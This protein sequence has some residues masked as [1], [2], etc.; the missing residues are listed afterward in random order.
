MKTMNYL[1]TVVFVLL[2]GSCT[3]E[4]HPVEEQLAATDFKSHKA[5][6]QEETQEIFALDMRQYYVLGQIAF[7]ERQRK[8]F[9]IGIE[10]GNEKLI[11]ELESTMRK[12]D[13]LTNELKE[14]LATSCSFLKLR[15]QLL[16]TDVLLGKD[17]AREAL[18]EVQ[19]KLEKCPK[20]LDVLIDFALET[21]EIIM[22]ITRGGDIGGA[23]KPGIDWSTCHER[24]QE[25]IL[26]I[27]YLDNQSGGH[28]V[29]YKTAG[30]KIISRGEMISEHPL[31]EGVQQ[32]IIELSPIDN[33]SLEFI[34]R[35][36]SFEQAINVR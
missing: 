30:G 12:I 1:F 20:K 15:A 23:C 8:E 25:G 13:D 22:A 6:E 3:N 4:S 7:L 5:Q 32:M 28:K 2:L 34:D 14:I 31:I 19:R 10:T 18:E 24:M 17:G 29:N 33:G 26:H 21:H 35:N 27:N 36:G 11:P 16:K 9:E